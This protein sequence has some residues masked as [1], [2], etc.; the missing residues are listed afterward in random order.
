IRN[1][2]IESGDDAICLKSTSSAVC[3]DISATGCRLKSNQGA[4]KLGT[5]S[6]GGFQN[7]NISNCQIHDTRNGG[8]K[9]LTV[10]GG[11]LTDVIISDITMDNVRTPIFIRLG[12]RLKT[13]RD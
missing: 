10:D 4:I 5:E 3:R 13:F 2:D 6:L 1:C 9:L 11:D 7:I 8:I 12:A